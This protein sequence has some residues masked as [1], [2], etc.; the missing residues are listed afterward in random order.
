[1]IEENRKPRILL[2][3]DVPSNIHILAEALEFD[4]DISVATNGQEALEIVKSVPPDLIL[5]DIIMPEMDGFEVCRQL[6]I[7]EDTKDI[8]VIFVTGAGDIENETV[9]FEM[10]AVDYF[11]KPI[12]PL[13]LRHR[14]KAHLEL[15]RQ[16]IAL[17][18]SHDHL[19]VVVGELEQ[20]TS[21]LKKRS[22]ELKDRE[23]NLWLILDNALDAIVSVDD[24]DK[25]QEFNPAAQEMFG[26]T[27][28]EI[29]GKNVTSLIVLP[30]LNEF[31]GEGVAHHL[32]K[33]GEPTII[34]KR[35]KLSG[36]RSDNKRV[37][38]EVGM[39]EITRN[40][41][42][43]V[44]AFLQ[45][46]TDHKQLIKSLGE[47]LDVAEKSNKAKSEFL[48]NMGHEIRSPMNAIMGMTEL[49]LSSKIT[50]DQR[51]NLEIAQ[52][53]SLN[54]MGLIN[55][56]M[57]FSKIEAGQLKI[58]SIPFD[59]RGQIENSCESLAIRGYQKNLEM[60]CD[61]APKIPTLI[62]DPL[63][64]NQVLINLVNNAIKFTDKGE[65]IV[66]V[67]R[68]KE[69]EIAGENIFLHFFVSDTGIGISEDR[70][71]LI[72]ERFTQADSS[73]T[74][75]YGGS[76]LGLT[77]SRHLVELMDGELWVDSVV[78]KG[79]VFHF[80]ANFAIGQRAAPDSI[81]HVEERQHQIEFTHLHGINIIV[82]DGNDSGRK[83]VKDMLNRFGADVIEVRDASQLLTCLKQTTKDKPMF[84]LIIMDH[85]MLGLELLD[86]GQ[87]LDPNKILTIIPPHLRVRDIVVNPHFQDMASIKKP[88]KLHS[89]LNNIDLLLKRAWVKED[90]EIPTPL[91]MGQE[92][93][94]L[95]I[96]LVEDLINNQKL[97]ISTLERVG[98]TVICVN[99]GSKALVALANDKYDLV[100]MDV[101]MPEMDGYEATKH[102][103][104]GKAGKCD[105]QI[106]IV[107]VTAR[108][109]QT[110]V[111]EYLASGMNGYL[112]K[113]YRAAEL[114]GVIELFTAT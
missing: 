91:P 61:I 30:N 89:L 69:K 21:D 62:G 53:S 66:R 20:R 64:L 71:A 45:D 101:H 92:I 15:R 102:I 41:K 78:G 24:D 74:R 87:M 27:R 107:A 67:E 65:I 11:I 42:R 40:Q 100:L 4:Y 84:D 75:K 103:R 48:A 106:P 14:V 94:P 97:A 7:I 96:L 12:H 77:I 13:K 68:L 46:I 85:G 43:H 72:F 22:A 83:I 95:R 25:I 16:K 34:K 31:N 55:D 23:A 36:V 37:D 10:G 98:H 44:T 8:P 114:I 52:N 1:M 56:L 38:L 73:T 113:P 60:Y 111:N 82:A 81:H 93:S 29:L 32:S 70:C 79:T 54:L 49:V 47:T 58:E 90:E 50:S 80:T 57:D 3:D 110:E 108:D 2:V 104:N 26:Y 86:A 19:A 5:L 28:D 109:I 63:R 105:T 59:L 51:E 17:Q 88:V 6:K 9:G 35:F 33:D 18:D 99:N 39:V 112:R 76:G